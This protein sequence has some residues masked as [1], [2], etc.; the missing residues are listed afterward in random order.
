MATHSAPADFAIG[1]VFLLVALPVCLLILAA[2]VMLFFDKTRKTGALL[3][4]V[5]VVLSVLGL[6]L[7]IGLARVRMERSR[8]A[9]E[10]K[11]AAWGPTV[12]VRVDRG[13]GSVRQ[14]A[15][16]PPPP[17]VM[18]AE[19]EPP[20]A[21]QHG[22]NGRPTMTR[23]L[24]DSVRSAIQSLPPMRGERLKQEAAQRDAGAA[25]RAEQVKQVEAWIATTV[26]REKEQ[27]RQKASGKQAVAAA[28]PAKNTPSGTP[29]A[30]A[31]VEAEDPA[32]SSVASSSPATPP[33]W[34]EAI[35]SE[36]DS[37][38][39]FPARVLEG[40]YQMVVKAGPYETRE[41]CESSLPTA[42]ERGVRQ[43]IARDLGEEAAG[44]IRLPLEFIA[45]RV[46]KDQVTEP[47]NT[48]F[49]PMVQV[50]A[51]LRFDREVQARIHEEWN[52]ILVNRRLWYAGG[53]LSGVLLLLS[54]VYGYLKA[55]LATQGAYRGRLRLLSGVLILA[56]VGAG[57]A[58]VK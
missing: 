13:R 16:T 28:T 39:E 58:L 26:A 29:P 1:V 9:T 30:K 10:F 31:A 22:G 4:F 51:L 11:S 37:P 41:E 21:A 32:G 52:R 44:R 2:L 48:S 56:L 19:R 49:G 34:L 35:T 42:L 7:F 46:V 50:H 12:G 25:R 57:L 55:D 18:S 24:A 5:P 36:P 40:S 38:A 6:V 33:P 14:P 47:V 53:A 23:A 54:V 17:V 45:T 8:P 15:S 3:L 27:A 20:A 43:F